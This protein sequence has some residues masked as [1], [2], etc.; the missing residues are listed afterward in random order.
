M[1]GSLYLCCLQLLELLV[2]LY[3]LSTLSNSALLLRFDLQILNTLFVPPSRL[4]QLE[5]PAISAT[6]SPASTSNNYT[7][8]HNEAHIDSTP[9]TSTCIRSLYLQSFLVRCHNPRR[10]F[11]SSRQPATEL[12]S[13]PQKLHSRSL[14]RRPYSKS[15][16]RRRDSHH[17]RQR[18]FP[19]TNRGWRN[20]FPASEIWIDHVD[21]TRSRYVRTITK[22]SHAPPP[23]PPCSSYIH[24]N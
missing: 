12:L 16:G 21:Q 23:P 7:D 14:H 1:I 8:S 10:S 18:Y 11:P 6:K 5:S 2:V 9:R 22:V 24:N 15:T 19:R 3:C 17:Q 20:C 4:C 13:R